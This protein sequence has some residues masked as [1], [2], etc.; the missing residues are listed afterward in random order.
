MD[1]LVVRLFIALGSFLNGERFDAIVG[2]CTECVF[3]EWA[4][5]N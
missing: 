5:K 4:F 1:R 2:V 3:K